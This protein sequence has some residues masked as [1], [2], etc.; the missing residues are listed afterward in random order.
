MFATH[1]VRLDQW[2]L[3]IKDRYGVR[4]P[5]NAGPDVEFPDVSSS[6]KRILERAASRAIVRIG[7][8]IE[9]RAR[10]RFASKP[11]NSSHFQGS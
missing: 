6:K 5:S 9:M 11:L 2:A 10:A 4:H 3:Q 8:R 1:W 7:A